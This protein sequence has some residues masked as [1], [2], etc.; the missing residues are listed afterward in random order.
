MKLTH[1]AACIAA[2]SFLTACGSSSDS[3]SAPA[4]N[5]EKAE[6]V[7]NTNADIALAAYTDSV[8][9]AEA[10]KSALATFK[11]TPNA[12]NLQ[13]AK[14]AWLVSR[15]PYGQT[16]VYRFRNSPIDSTDYKSE[17]GPEG[18]LNAWPLG[19]ALIDYV[20][21]NTT[22]FTAGEIGV[23]ANAA[24]INNNG[25]VD[26]SVTNQNIIQSDVTINA[27]LLANTATASDEHDVISGYHAIE[28]LLWGQDLNTQNQT[29]TNGADRN[30]A[31]NT[32]KAGGQRPLTDFTTDA[33]AARRHAYLEVAVDKLIADL[34]G[35]RDGWKA[36]ATYRTAFVSMT[37]E[38]AAKQKLTEILT[39]MGTLSEGE[40]AGERMQIAYSSNSQEDEHSCFSD[41]THRDVWLNAEGVSN[42]F[43][44][45]YAGYDSNQDGTDDVTTNA[46]NG[47]GI[48]DY[49]RDVGLDSLA[50][51]AVTAFAATQTNYTAIDT[52]ARAG[53]PFDVLIMDENRNATNPVALTIISLNKQSRV[54]QEI[55]T[56][57]GLGTVVDE[58]ASSC[59]TSSPGTTCD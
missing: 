40:L 35:V 20:E 43:Y 30:L 23:T 45:K 58:D 36:G 51:E 16:E 1:L 17:D 26:G 13:A 31:V 41:N 50:D 47:Y 48:N 15:E 53:S 55:A 52:Q 28:F 39:G 25:V 2:A 38:A 33:N 27:D 44:G 12:E 11:T 42:S 34:E 10:L 54:I 29:T 24:G 21:G 3:D 5:M 59:D 9:T 18:D 19:E 56:E 37:G 46:V 6:A 7:L 49:L 57:L 32:G 8:I 14:A 4:I 22:D